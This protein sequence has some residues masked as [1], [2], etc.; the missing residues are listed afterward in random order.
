MIEIDDA[1]SGSLIGG[2]GIG[3]L[4]K[5]TQEY[6]FDLIPIHCFQPPAFSEKKYQDYVINIVK[7]AFKQLQISKKETIYLCPSY[8]FDHL[9]KWLSTQGYHWQNTKIV[10]PLQNKVETSFNHYVIRLGLP[11]NFVIHARYAFG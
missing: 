3:I 9:R 6:F 5:E 11:T 1:G 4:K 10:G 7:K 2:T 8:I